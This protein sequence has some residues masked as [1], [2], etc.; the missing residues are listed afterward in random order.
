M[1][2]DSFIISV[3][4]GVIIGSVASDFFSVVAGSVFASVLVAGASAR[5]MVFVVS[6]AFLIFCPVSVLAGGVKAAALSWAF[7]SGAGA[8]T[9]VFCSHAPRSAAL[10]RMQINFFIVV[11][12]FPIYGTKLESEQRNFSALP[13]FLI[14]KAEWGKQESA[15]EDGKAGSPV[16]AEI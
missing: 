3:V 10:A 14:K 9:S 5:L 1:V 12:W 13:K 15:T 4:M 8:T 11:D 7:F 2:A 6:V 16:A